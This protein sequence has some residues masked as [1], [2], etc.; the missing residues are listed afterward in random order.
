MQ[1]LIYT[2]F[3][4]KLST[5][6]SSLN[7]NIH[8]KTFSSSPTKP[9]QTHLLGSS[10]L[11]HPVK[12]ANNHSWSSYH[13]LS[14]LLS[15]SALLKQF[16]VNSST[17]LLKAHSKTLVDCKFLFFKAQFSKQSFNFG[18][19]GRGWNSW[20]QGLSA[21]DMVLGLILANADLI[22][23]FQKR[24][25]THFSYFCIQSHRYGAPRIQHDR[26]ISRSF[27][28]DY[29]LK[30]YLAGAI[31]GSIFYLVHH[32]VLSLSSKGGGLFRMDPSRTPG[33]G[34]SG[35]VNAIM[36]LDIF[37]NPRA[38]LY[39]DFFIPVPAMLL[40]IFLIG[41]DILRM[42]EGDSNISGSAH[43]G[44][45]TVAALAWFRLRKGRF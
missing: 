41:K 5:R 23:Q 14:G 7:P 6:T 32:A 33:L 44:G 28:P 8:Y 45:A 39:F 40:G 37:L 26:A 38:T 31:G 15:K 34:A 2:K 13:S 12:L 25:F 29:L 24:S 16:L 36:L 10:S 19:Q 42:I 18:S 22:G 20:F 3:A 30:L 1:R 43:L 27:G 11:T 35:A 21:N 9:T 17:T 4:S